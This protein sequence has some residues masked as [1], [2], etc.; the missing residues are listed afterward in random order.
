MNPQHD[1]D[2]Q[3]DKQ[4]KTMLVKNTDF[5]GDRNRY[6]KFEQDEATKNAA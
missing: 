6:V 5:F 1:L 3:I 4:L 2:N